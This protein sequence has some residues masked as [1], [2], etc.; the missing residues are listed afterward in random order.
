MKRLSRPSH[1]KIKIGTATRKVS[2]AYRMLRNK[3]LAA[4]L[5]SVFRAIKVK[6]SIY[7]RGRDK[8]ISLD[9]CQFDLYKIPNTRMKLELLTGAYEHRERSAARRYIRREWAVVELGGCIGVVA[10]V[11]NK[12]LQSPAA[13]VVL[14]ANP[15]AIPHL[16]SNRDANHCSFKI[17]N[18]AL[19]YNA[20]TVT[21]S[22]W[23]DLWNNSLHHDGAHQPPVTVQTTE[24]RQI[25][26]EER[27]D[28]FAL[29]CDIEG[30]EYE[31]VMREADVLRAAELIIM[32]VHPQ[33][34]GEEKVQALMSGLADL[35][36]KTI[37]TSSRVT[38]LS[39]A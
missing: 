36:F 22:P 2:A 32:E 14:E 3:G 11:T 37:E 1:Y 4:F 8:V 25:L 34:I 20:N 33:V 39:K 26:Q 16:K 15:L 9:G 29:I 6:V 24:L 12:L 38:V 21:F 10:C 28:K 35:G 27:F 19:A 23:L 13:H 7:V 30:Q 18:R 31:L 17:V 5:S